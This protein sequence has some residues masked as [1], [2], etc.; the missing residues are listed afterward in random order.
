MQK[1]DTMKQ[2]DDPST[3]RSN[4]VRSN[5]LASRQSRRSVAI[6]DH[7]KSMPKFEAPT[8]SLQLPND[9][10][11]DAASIHEDLIRKTQEIDDI[12]AYFDK[13]M[14]QMKQKHQSMVKDFSEWQI[15]I[16]ENKHAARKLERRVETLENMNEEVDLSALEGKGTVNVADII[17][18][19]QDVQSDILN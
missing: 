8:A 5:V 14:L 7:K 9:D 4:S 18:V 17:K 2:I 12:I 19:I 3:P 10:A 15:T 11:N 1:M 16:Q 13:K 6:S